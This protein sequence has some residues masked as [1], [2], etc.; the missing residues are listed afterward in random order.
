MS[1]T[2]QIKFSCSGPHSPVWHD[3]KFNETLTQ[4]DSM[5]LSATYLHLVRS[6]HDMLYFKGTITQVEGYAT[7]RVVNNHDVVMMTG[8]PRLLLQDYK[9]IYSDR[10]VPVT[11]CIIGI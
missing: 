9:Y 7:Y 6:F 1:N 5:S 10:V 4:Q 3:S 11:S 8:D 2:Y